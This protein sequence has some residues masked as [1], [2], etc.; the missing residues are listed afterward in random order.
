MIINTKSSKIY[1]LSEI[2]AGQSAKSILKN[3]SNFEIINFEDQFFIRTNDNEYQWGAQVPK[4]GKKTR[5]RMTKKEGV[6]N[7]F[8][9]VKIRTEDNKSIKK[10]NLKYPFSYFD[11]NNETIKSEYIITPKGG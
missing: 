8:E 7:Y 4:E 3:E 9:N 1:G 5:V 2:L 10:S 11:G 6:V